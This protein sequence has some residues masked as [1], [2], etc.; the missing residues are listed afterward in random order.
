[1]LLYTYDI[2]NVWVH[3][4]MEEQSITPIQDVY[5]SYVRK[6]DIRQMIEIFNSKRY[7]FSNKRHNM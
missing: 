7:Y 4:R 5:V 2:T 1:M 6:R 3:T